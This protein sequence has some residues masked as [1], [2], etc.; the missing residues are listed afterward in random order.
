MSKMKRVP[1]TSPKTKEEVPRKSKEEIELESQ[2]IFLFYMTIQKG[3]KY[4]STAAGA[5]FLFYYGV[6]QALNVTAGKDTNVNYVVSFLEKTRSSNWLWVIVTLIA[7][8]WAKAERSLRLRD[9]KIKD[10]RITTLEQQ[11]D[12]NRTSSGLSITGESKKK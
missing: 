8:A 5:Y 3:L 11:I 10:S 9:R 4:L 1:R 2:K 6:Y 7:V 12:P